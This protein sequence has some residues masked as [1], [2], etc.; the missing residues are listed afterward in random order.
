MERRQGRRGLRPL[1]AALAGIR[2][3]APWTQSESERQL[4][5]LLRALGIGG[6]KRVAEVALIGIGVTL[7]QNN[8][9]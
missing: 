7:Y 4:L 9:V 3:E 6:C 1:A 5:A 2:D 8:V